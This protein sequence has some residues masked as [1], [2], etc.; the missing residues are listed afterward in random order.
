MGIGKAPSIVA[1]NTDMTPVKK[2]YYTMHLYI[3]RT[4]VLQWQ[5]HAMT[6]L[7][8]LMAL[9]KVDVKLQSGIYTVQY[10]WQQLFY[11]GIMSFRQGI[12]CS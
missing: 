10:Q 1:A 11:V 5:H 12:K 3:F 6:Y 2:T 7:N 9:M 8:V 4:L